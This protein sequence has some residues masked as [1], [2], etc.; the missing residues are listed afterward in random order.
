MRICFHIPII[1][2]LLICVTAYSQTQQG[3]VKA[4]GRM[5][6]SGEVIP[7]TR[8]PDATVQPKDRQAVVS[9]SNGTFSFPVTNGSYALQNVF[10]QGY[11]L[12][13]PEVLSRQY[14]YSSNP[15]VLV[16]ERPEEQ[17][18]DKLLAERKIRRTLQRQLQD[19]EDE[20]E[21]LKATKQLEEEEYRQTLQKLYA[22]QENNEALISGMADRYSKLDFD[23]LDDFNQQISRLILDGKLSEADSLLNSKG[24][25]RER[26]GALKR[27]QEANAQEEQHLKRRQKKLEKSKALTQKELEDLAQDCYSKFEIFKMRHQNDSAAYYLG[28]RSELDSTNVDYLFELGD[29]IKEYFA[30]YD[31]AQKYYESASVIAKS[32]DPTGK[33]FIT[34]LVCIAS[35]HR[36]KGE[37]A[38]AQERL[39]YALNLSRQFFGEQD[40]QTARIYSDIGVGY[41]LLSQYDLAIEYFQKDLDIS[42]IHL[43]ETHKDIGASYSNLARVHYAKGDYSSALELGDKAIAIDKL[44]Y[45]ENDP[46][47]ATDYSNQGLVFKKMGDYTKDSSYY[48]KALE[49]YSKALDIRLEWYGRIH[50]DVA[51]VY[52]NIGG[53]YKSLGDYD[54]ALEYHLKDLEISERILGPEH[55]D[56]ATSINNIGVVYKQKGEFEQALAYY[57]LALQIRKKVFPEESTQVADVYT[58]MGS[59]FYSMGENEKALQYYEE[60]Y[61]VFLKLIGPEHPVVKALK[62]RT[63]DIEKA[64][65]K[66]I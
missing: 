41:Y 20:L 38:L 59:L 66:E 21:A 43:G 14:A 9:K 58:N 63:R 44:N 2:F 8:L 30:H 61:A 64:M 7:G 3:Y 19:K 65:D 60:A 28:L 55:P 33:D 31:N 18:E 13:D 50:P 29:F 4:K 51:I 47:L 17:L 1:V 24:D 11:I 62:K 53:V 56:V 40:L 5:N 6:A 52:N 36:D 22:D 54:K 46:H 26:A 15:L 37:L 49:L 35:V 23:A 12:T 34:S 42:M 57:Q 48:T 32:N 27:H 10:K 45:G 16:L 39:E 25:I